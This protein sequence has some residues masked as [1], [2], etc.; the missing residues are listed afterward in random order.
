MVSKELK[1]EAFHLRKIGHSYKYIEAQ[2]GISKSTLSGWFSGK[3]F[4]PNQFTLDKIANGPKISAQLRIKARVQRTLKIWQ[5]AEQQLGTLT[6]RDLLILGIGLYM[7]EGSKTNSIVRFSNSDPL[8][9]KLFI[10]WSTESFGVSSQNF[11]LR[12]HTYPDAN[13]GTVEKYWLK[14]TGLPK[15]SLRRTFI[16]KRT[17][18]VQ[19][20]GKLPYGTAHLTIFAAGN[21][22]HGVE[23][24][25]L[26][27]GYIRAVKQKYAGIV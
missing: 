8:M 12:I 7:G 25:R 24:F 13:I 23:L 6:S 10:K 15:S 9:I 14:T 20:S 2:L 4:T 27:E 22:K 19:K 18:K 21:T 16:D 3:E 5:T 26:I 1:A 17:N 11:A